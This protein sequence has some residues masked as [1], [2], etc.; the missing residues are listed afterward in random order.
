MNLR[1]SLWWIW[2]ILIH[3]LTGVVIFVTIAAAAAGLD[4]ASQWVGKIG[5]SR[6]TQYAL[7][8]AECLLLLAD[9]ALLVIFIWE[10]IVGSPPPPPRST[11]TAATTAS[12]GL[13]NAKKS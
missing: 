12:A 6:S 8:A 4:F 2:L 11:S 10:T 3:V 9:L 13:L 1:R 7:G 5:L